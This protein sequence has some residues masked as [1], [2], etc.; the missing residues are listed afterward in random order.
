MT[1]PLVSRVLIADDHA[2]VRR[3]GALGVAEDLPVM[4][5]L[6]DGADCIEIARALGLD[7]DDV[8][9]RGRRIVGLLQA[10]SRAVG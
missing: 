2:V 4:A 8:V 6:A 10:R 1:V 7:R 3:G 5:L 9:R